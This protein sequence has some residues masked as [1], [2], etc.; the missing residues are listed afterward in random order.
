MPIH[1]FFTTPRPYWKWSASMTFGA[2]WDSGEFSVCSGSDIF[3][4][5]FFF[6]SP[7]REGCVHSLP[8]AAAG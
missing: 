2:G 6:L 7:V 4:C 8:D 5:C 3:V 1:F